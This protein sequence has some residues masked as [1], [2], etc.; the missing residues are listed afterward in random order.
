MEVLDGMI[1]DVCEIPGRE[2]EVRARGRIRM[3]QICVLPAV[4]LS[5]VL[6]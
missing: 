4:R 3:F 2:D 5:V 1:R 6:L